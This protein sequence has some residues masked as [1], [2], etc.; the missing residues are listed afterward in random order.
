M[1][2]NMLFIDRSQFWTVESNRSKILIFISIF[3]N[4]YDYFRQRCWWLERFL[5]LSYKWIAIVF[6]PLDVLGCDWMRNY[7]GLDELIQLAET[8]SLHWSFVLQFKLERIY[9]TFLARYLLLK[10]IIYLSNRLAPD[11][12]DSIPVF[13]CLF[14]RTLSLSI[15]LFYCIHFY[16]LIWITVV[17]CHDVFILKRRQI[18]FVLHLGSEQINEELF[19][20]SVYNMDIIEKKVLNVVII[21]LG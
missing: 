3:C 8:F 1:I 11:S 19:C 14:A 12:F 18:L 2:K 10:V 6:G 13:R 9:F 7:F 17:T 15:S 16:V 5:F 20:L 4:C 21:S